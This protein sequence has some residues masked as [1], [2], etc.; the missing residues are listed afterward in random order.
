[1]SV[2]TDSFVQR[3]LAGDIRAS[4]RLM[5]DL[6]DRMPDALHTL[7]ELYRHAGRAQVIGITGPPGS[8]KSTLVDALI[9]EYRRQNVRVGVVAVDPSSPFSGG[10]ILGD[11]I[12]MNRHAT[13]PGVFIRSL[14]SRG[15]LGG[16]SRSTHDVVT[17]L[18]AM[19]YERI[20]IETV[21]VGQAEVDIVEAAHL[22]VVVVVP[23]L[24]DEIQAIK[25]GILEIA[26][27]LCLNKADRDGADRTA[28]DLEL[29]LML[30]NPSLP[31]PPILRTV[32]SMNQG[33]E[34]LALSIT[35]ILHR[36]GMQTWEARTRR[37]VRKQLEDLLQHHLTHAA[38]A[39]LEIQLNQWIE[40][41][42]N[43]EIDP[44]SVVEIALKECLR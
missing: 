7:K 37:R 11:R 43:R 13:D 42:A 36:E 24:G 38:F 2:T 15:H 40:Q 22:A 44:Y 6:D 27:I 3:I 39:K 16:L 26:D 20:L 8:G 23:G 31:K 1:M 9:S 19:G 32:A 18:D 34:E 35:A 17:V 29:M 28:H 10:A 5:R 12:R 21:G 25:A 41:I 14:A 33:I 30:R 4:A